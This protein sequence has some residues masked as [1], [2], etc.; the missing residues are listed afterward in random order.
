MFTPYITLQTLAAVTHRLY[1]DG[2]RV[3]INK[4]KL[5]EKKEMEN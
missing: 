2:K 4:K 1:I 5:N 3:L